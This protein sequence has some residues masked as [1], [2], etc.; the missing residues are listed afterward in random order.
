MVVYFILDMLI[1]VLFCIVYFF[2][3]LEKFVRVVFKIRDLMLW[4]AVLIVEM[5]DVLVVNMEFGGWERLIIYRNLW[6]YIYVGVL[7]L[8]FIVFI[9]FWKDFRFI[10]FY[11]WFNLFFFVLFI[12]LFVWRCFIIW[13]VGNMYF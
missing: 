12:K 7:I 4:C 10:F 13:G 1:Y 6:L 2:C 11:C 5:M 3:L 9:K 8:V